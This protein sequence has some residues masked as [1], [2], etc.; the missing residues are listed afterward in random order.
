MLNQYSVR[1][2]TFDGLDETV[3]SRILNMRPM[4]SN[5]VIFARP[6][7]MEIL[8]ENV[9]FVYFS[10]T[11]FSINLLNFYFTTSGAKVQCD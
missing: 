10:N 5:F 11:I 8:L 6:A 9:K 4:P 3:A 2:I 1:S 7:E